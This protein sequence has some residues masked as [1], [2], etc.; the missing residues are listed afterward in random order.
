MLLD[1]KGT[2]ATLDHRDPEVFKV[3]QG[4]QEN[5]ER[6]VVTALMV[7]EVCQE[8]LGPR[9]TEVSTASLV[10]PERRDTEENT[11]HRVLRVLQERTAQEVKMARLDREVWP[12]R[13]VLEVCLAPEGL[14][15]L[16]DS[17]AF[18]DLMGKPVPKET[19]VHKERQG[20]MGSRVCLFHMVLLVLKVQ[21]VLLVTKDLKVN[22][23]WL[24][25]L[26]Q[27]VLLVIQ[28]K[29]VLQAR[30]EHLVILV[31]WDPSATLGPV[32]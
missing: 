31:L 15:V 9:V 10:S 19:W 8:S 24:G 32:V 18:P 3:R 13:V 7:L 29:R 6:G 12:E 4:L 21:S 26:V 22:K 5:Q 25:F 1:L 27:M 11:V 2:V 14:K 17:A 20:L 16:G 23:V 30:K 28:E